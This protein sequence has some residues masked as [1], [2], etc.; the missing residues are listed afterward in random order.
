MRRR[1]MLCSGLHDAVMLARSLHHRLPF[2]DVVG[3]RLFDIDVLACF[4]SENGGNGM[5]MI[6]S[7]YQ[8][9][10]DVLALENL[11]EILVRLGTRSHPL[12]A[13]LCVVVENI[14]RADKLN[15]GDLRH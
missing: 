5:P 4:A 14:P 9:C 8:D 2:L 15:A 6:W 3:Q 13:F 7:T 1:S 12:Q 11:P 10:I